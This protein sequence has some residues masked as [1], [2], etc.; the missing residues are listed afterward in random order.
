[1][2]SMKLTKWFCDRCKREIN[3]VVY[4]LSCYA[5]DAQPAPFGLSAE[6]ANQNVTQNRSGVAE[7]HLCKACKD[8][9]TDGVFIV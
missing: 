9:L 6:A 5:H 7:R 8:D 3:G 1:M 2:R 4:T